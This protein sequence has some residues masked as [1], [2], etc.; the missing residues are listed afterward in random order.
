MTLVLPSALRDRGCCPLSRRNRDRCP[1]SGH[2]T[3]LTE[4]LACA[5]SRRICASSLSTYICSHALRIYLR[6]HSWH[7]SVPHPGGPLCL[8]IEATIGTRTSSPISSPDLALYSRPGRPRLSTSSYGQNVPHAA[9]WIVPPG[10]RLCIRHICAARH[11]LGRQSSDSSLFGRPSSLSLSTS[12]YS[13][14]SPALQTA[15]SCPAIH[16][17]STHPHRT[18]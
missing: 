14:F 10:C 17:H 6:S 7:V 9:G 3:R 5:S 4:C 2:F 13:M 1:R 11:V 18:S 8:S 15:S 16:L 12:S